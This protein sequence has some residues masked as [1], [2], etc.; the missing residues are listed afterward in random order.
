MK[1]T[2]ETSYL[3]GLIQTDGHLYQNTRNRGS[4]TIELADL[5]KDI[6]YKIAKLIPYDYSISKRK[7]KTNFS[8]HSSSITLRV[9]NQEFRKWINESGVPYGKKSLIVKPPLYL[10]KLSINDYIR[11]LWDGDGSVGYTKTKIPFLSFTTNSLN[12]KDFLENYISKITGNNHHHFSKPKRDNVFNIMITKEDAVALASIL[13]PKNSKNISIKRKF[14]NAQK[15][16]SWKR[17]NTM[18]QVTWKRANWAKEE[19]KYLLKNGIK[20]TM[21]KYNRTFKSVSIRLWRLSHKT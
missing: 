11:G 10:K 21:N 13:Y 12:I 18:K 17:P 14:I 20:S 15:I 9:Y 1:I 2:K 3:I 6:I 5:D 4:L 16:Q 7:R 19:D 8:D